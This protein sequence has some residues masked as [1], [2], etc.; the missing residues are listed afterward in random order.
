MTTYDD[1]N[2]P[3]VPEPEFLGLWVRTR[4]RLPRG[5][6]VTFENAVGGTIGYRFKTLRAALAYQ[7]K[8]LSAKRD[9]REI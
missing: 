9:M 7:T 5:Y 8:L 4:Q 2:Q 3:W 6:T 1:Q